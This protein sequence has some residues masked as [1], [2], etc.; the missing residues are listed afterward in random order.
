MGKCKEMSPNMLWKLIHTMRVDP[1][2]VPNFG[3]N[4]QT[5]SLI[6]IEPF[7]DLWKGFEM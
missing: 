1:I 6:Q 5:T 7:L 4:V 3:I 2:V